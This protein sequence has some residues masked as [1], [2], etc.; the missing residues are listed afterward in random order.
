MHKPSLSFCT[1]ESTL[2]KRSSMHVNACTSKH[3]QM[4]KWCGV[5]RREQCLL[6]DDLPQIALPYSP[7]KC[8]IWPHHLV[9][10]TLTHVQDSVWI[11]AL[12]LGHS[13]GTDQRQHHHFLLSFPTSEYCKYIFM[14]PAAGLGMQALPSYLFMC[15][16]RTSQRN[17]T[18]ASC[19]V[20]SHME[21]AVYK[22]HIIVQPA[23]LLI[24][25]LHLQQPASLF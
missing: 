13:C 10:E 2:N 7:A 12:L 8:R 25:R 4:H 15:F 19:V 20:L 5:G 3:T 23:M 1:Y 17:D 24:K 22:W 21:A 14:C 18:P 16:R 6:S 9:F 11:C